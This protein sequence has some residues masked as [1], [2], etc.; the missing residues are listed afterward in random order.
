MVQLHPFRKIACL[1]LREANYHLF[2]RSSSV[3]KT[4]EDLC[5]GWYFIL[6]IPYIQL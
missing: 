4:D 1:E 5:H 3:Y 2:I 6:M